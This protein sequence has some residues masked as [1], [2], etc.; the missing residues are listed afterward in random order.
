MNLHIPQNP[1]ATTECSTICRTAY[2][3]VSAQHSS[4]IMGCVQ[5]TLLL[6]Y[7]M[8]ETFTTPS[9]LEPDEPSTATFPLLEGEEGFSS[10]PKKNG[11]IP[12]Y[13]TLIDREDFMDAIM[14]AHISL[15]R[16]NDLI[17]RVKDYYPQYLDSRGKLK[18]QIPGKIV[19][20]IVFPR[21]FNWQRVTKTNE[22][23]PLVE[24]EN[25]MITPRSGPLCKKCIGA[26]SYSAI[27][28]IWKMSP[29]LACQVISE[30][31]A[32]AS[33]ILPRIGFS[34]GI[35]DCLTTSRKEVED[36]LAKA[37]IECDIINSDTSKTSDE[38]E[39][40][41]NG[42][43]N[44]AMSAAAKMTKTSMYRKDRN[45]LVIM[46]KS[47]AKG[48]DSNNIQIAAFVGQQN[49]DGK[50]PQQ[51]LSGGTRTLS[52]VFPGDNSP[53]AR[54][55]VSH[56]Y[57]QGLT[58][59][60]AVFHAATGRRGVIDTA[61]KTADTGY[62]QKRMV[63]K[64]GDLRVEYDGSVRDA[65]G[66]VVQFL[67]GGDGWN[68]KEIIS[69]RNLNHLFFMDP[70]AISSTLNSIACNEERELGIPKGVKRELIK[71]EIE[72][73]L[74]FLQAGA[75]GIQTE[76]T[77]RFTYNV[78]V[79]TKASLKGVELYTAVIPRFCLKVRDEFEVA[80]AKKGYMPGLIAASSVGEPTTQLV[81]NTFHHAGISDKDVTL[82]V[83]RFKELIG[84]THNPS[85]PSTSIALLDENLK[86]AAQKSF[87]LSKNTD[88]KSKKKVSRIE[89]DATKR[90][91]S[92]ATKF[93]RLT[94]GQLTKRIIPQYILDPKGEIPESTPTRLLKYSQY[95]ERWWVKLWKS[96]GNELKFSPDG[97]WVIILQLDIDLLYDFDLSV[98]DI[99]KKIEEE[100]Y[101]VRG[102]TLTCI[103]SP[104]SIGQ[105]EV[106]INFSDIES[107][108]ETKKVELPTSA[109]EGG[110]GKSLLTTENMDYFSARDVAIDLI[111]KTVVQG[112]PSITKTF[113][114]YDAL[115]KERTLDTQGTNLA[116]ILATPG[117]DTTKTVSDEMWELFRC[118]GIEV[119]RTF[120]I[121]EMT[122]IISFDGAT[123]NK[124]H[125]SILVDE[126]VRGGG[127]TSVSRDG[128]SRTSCIAK[129]TFE[130]SLDNAVESAMFCEHDDLKGMSASIMMGSAICAGTGTTQVKDGDR[131]P[132]EKR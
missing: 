40:A 18:A 111:K 103:P 113:V 76:V 131:M 72:L 114:K 37:H 79:C 57:L 88:S 27:H 35:S 78:R 62:M 43:L 15:D 95:R 8:T 29:D 51:V 80:K 6:Q 17:R 30:L 105:I 108:L 100:A 87:T 9:E 94:V 129:L 125:I 25:G 39:R 70:F 121:K 90:A 83:P 12:G 28:P 59:R 126:M 98:A 33:V 24:I 116:A 73:L 109:T 49:I 86:S 7:L 32:I 132:V 38:K 53:E 47:G 19:A 61:M 119:A 26:T 92:I 101:G 115:T 77:E 50:R 81:L 110:K 45:A 46:K 84:T 107:Y 102:H 56:S 67:Y 21:E 106:Y 75:P 55:F 34:M 69:T 96:L 91:T 63:Q 31:Q 41:I 2:H 60:E 64:E 74:G 123:V 89:I 58:P 99:A 117:V 85:K 112:L 20:S 4:P 118:F 97:S 54:G 71:E 122:R 66:A 16:F 11:S 3:V 44:G 52:S 82:G 93:T 127:I 124:R 13:E 68:A 36:A 5:N 120:I 128:I 23:L 14:T 48:S 22:R 1:L 65:A 104:L 130:R 10:D 42:I